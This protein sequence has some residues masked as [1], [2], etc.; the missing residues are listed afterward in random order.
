MLTG[1]FTM[2]SLRPV[3]HPTLWNA[4]M[5]QESPRPGTRRPRLARVASLCICAI[6]ALVAAAVPAH[7]QSQRSVTVQTQIFGELSINK[8]KDLDFGYII[9]TTAG[10]I[11]MVPDEDPTCTATGGIVHSGPCQPAQFFGSGE[12]GRVVRIKKPSGQKITLTGPGADMSITGLVIDGSP[13]L[14]EIN[15]TPGYSRYRI[16]SADGYFEFRFGGTLNVGAA[17]TPGVYTGTFEVT[18]QYN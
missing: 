9:G 3:N 14:A 13:D 12:S 5:D 16:D 15:V 10:T 17:Q 18:I 1:A 11:V 8:D 7:A 2:T 6:I 4:A